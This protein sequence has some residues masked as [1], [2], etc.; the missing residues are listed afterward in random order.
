QSPPVIHRDLKPQNIVIDPKGQV[1]LIDF[2]I[3]REHK[4][5]NT[6]DTT[7]ILTG[8]YAAPEQFG[9][10]QTSPLTDIYGLGVVMVFMATGGT[11]KTQL[12]TVIK[13]E[14][15]YQI[16]KKCIAFDPQE[17]FQTTKELEK[18]VE[19]A[20]KKSTR[21]RKWLKGGVVFLVI[22]FIGGISGYLSFRQGEKEGVTS[23]YPKGYE[24][25]YLQGERDGYLEGEKK[26][27]NWSLAP[28]PYQSGEKGWVTNM[29]NGNFA[30]QW[31]EGV[32][33]VDKGEI[34]HL[35]DK[36]EKSLFLENVE[37]V[38]CITYWEGYLYFARTY[39]K[40]LGIYRVNPQNLEI[41]MLS[42]DLTE[43]LDCQDNNLYFLDSYDGLTL[44]RIDLKDF[45]RE[46]MNNISSTVYTN[47]NGEKMYYADLE[48]GRRLYVASLDGKNVEKIHETGEH[49][50]VYDNHLYFF[51]RNK[52]NGSL[53]Q[54]DLKGEKEQVLL[55]GMP[56]AYFTASKNGILYVRTPHADQKSLEWCSFDGRQQYVILKANVGRIS[57]AGEWVFYENEDDGDALWQV[58]LTGEENQRVGGAD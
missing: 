8:P 16:I 50:C 21:G 28:L 4:P 30:T 2:G 43:S 33:Y 47:I 38:S 23:T 14:D 22:L 39:D 53:L 15:L 24:A 27:P 37:D 49:L 6:Q 9:F 55:S 25:G 34:Y 54:T 11:E 57:V 5:G 32:F 40:T 42:K 44:C 31:E 48:L 18:E 3:A 58:K 45:R 56:L 51:D 20:K 12:Q 10:E 19:K 46:K 17:R 52:Y 35:N 26:A 7:I 29:H 13:N 41:E 36:G 1:K